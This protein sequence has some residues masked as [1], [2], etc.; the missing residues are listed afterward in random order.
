[1]TSPGM[2]FI[3][4]SS[5]LS[6]LPL[7]Y[8]PLTSLLR[9]TRLARMNTPLRRPVLHKT[10]SSFSYLPDGPDGNHPPLPSHTGMGGWRQPDRTARKWLVIIDYGPELVATTNEIQGV[11]EGGS[12]LAPLQSTVC[13]MV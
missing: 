10:T 13:R 7:S 8:A 2:A 5:I 6:V 9:S 4:R 1:M 12:L 11:S 3:C